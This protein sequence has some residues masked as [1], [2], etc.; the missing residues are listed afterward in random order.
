MEGL[1]DDTLRSALGSV[2][3]YDCAVSEFLRVSASLLS[4]RAFCRTVPELAHGGRT[5]SGMPVRVQLLG[6]DPAM[7]AANAAQLATLGPEA[8]D[9]NFGCPAPTV[10]RH[11]GGAVLLDEPDLL[12]AIV[13]AVR[14]ALPAEM[15][16]TAKMRLGVADTSR[17]LDCAHALAAGGVAELVVHARTRDEGYRPP[18]H[19]EWVGQIAAAVNVPVV[20]NGEIWTVADWQRCRAVSGVADVMLGRGAV[21]D[22]FLARRIRTGVADD[23]VAMRDAEWAELSGI[24][25]GFCAQVGARLMP[26]QAAGRVKQWFN[27]LRR[28]YWQAEALYRRICPLTTMVEIERVFGDQT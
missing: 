12:F 18:A 28:R 26:R 2:G 19:W 8:V 11:R 16:L 21:T 4:R 7:L 14:A 20:A 25:A 17:A 10:N 23:N 3:T 6:S 15:P 13:C 9:L 5:A 27:F 22:P 24:V 1:V